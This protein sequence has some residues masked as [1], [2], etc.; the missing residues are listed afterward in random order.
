MA[1]TYWDQ[2]DTAGRARIMN[3]AARA[4]S[5]HKRVAEATAE[6]NANAK[7]KP[8]ANQPEITGWIIDRAPKR[9]PLIETRGLD[10]RDRMIAAK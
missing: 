3:A 9:F 6:A 4:A 2:L 1:K 8:K 5:E 7:A 10:W